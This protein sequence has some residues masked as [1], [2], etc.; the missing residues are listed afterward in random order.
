MPSGAQ[1]CEW[2]EKYCRIPQGRL[3][4]QPVKLPPFMVDDL[5]AIY[6][7]P[8]GTRRA[9]ISRGRKNAKTTE[10]TFL[11]LLHLCGPMY[12]RNGHIYS[13]AQGLEQAGILFRLA[14]QMIRMSPVLRAAVEIKEARKEIVCPELGTVYRA[15]SAETS[16]AYGLS[17]VL[18]IHDELGQCRGPRSELYEALETATAA[19]ENPLSVI[20]STQAPTDNDLLSILIDDALG[21]HDPRT[22]IRLQ[23]APDE[24]DP[25]SDEAIRAANP[26]FDFFMNRDE[27]RGMAEDARRMAGRENDYR[28]L[29]LNQRVEALAPFVSVETWK[30]CNTPVKPLDDCPEVFAGLDLSATKDLTA[31]VLIGKVDNVWQIVPHF[32]LP[33]DG[34]HERARLDRVPYDLWQR[35]GFLTTT[36]G[37]TIDYDFVVDRLLEMFQRYAVKK[38]AFDKWNFNQFKSYLLRAGM[39]EDE[40]KE[41]F[42]PFRQNFQEMSPALKELDR[43]LSNQRMAHGDHP[44]LTMCAMNSTVLTDNHENIKLVKKKFYGRIDGMIALAMAVGVVPQQIKVEPKYEV[45]FIG[46]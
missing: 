10:S 28:N 39:S 1:G 26:A 22:L 35:N 24:L 11:V 30:K 20:I 12:V 3:I 19:Q 14:C 18:I 38:V 40:V 17:P 2:I 8:N 16:T 29:V 21:G 43:H 33:K 7:N 15:L 6:D 44:V 45:F 9:I 42:V 36:P 25:F 34:L 27:V 5:C 37:K 23:V 31:L 4:G 46:R 13:A 32:W 41:K